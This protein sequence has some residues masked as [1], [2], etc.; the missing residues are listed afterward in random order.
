MAIVVYME[1]L[2]LLPC[3]RFSKQIHI[4]CLNNK[5]FSNL[6]FEKVHVCAQQMFLLI[7]CVLSIKTI[8]MW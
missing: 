8:A 2:K 5:E 1:I 7:K 3:Q 6:D 4:L